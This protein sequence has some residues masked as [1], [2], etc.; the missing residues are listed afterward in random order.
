LGWKESDMATRR[1]SDPGKLKLAVRL[2]TDT[3]LSIKAIARR[4]GLGTSWSA[5]VRLHEWMKSP[6]ATA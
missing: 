1:K 3:T 2:R 6:V 5:N 4:I